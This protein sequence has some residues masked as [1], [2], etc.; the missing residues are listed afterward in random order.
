MIEVVVELKLGLWP[1]ELTISIKRRLF[2][3]TIFR[4]KQ[5]DCEIFPFRSWV[6]PGLFVFQA[7]TM[8]TSKGVFRICCAFEDLSVVCCLAFAAICHGRNRLTRSDQE[9][10][11]GREPPVANLLLRDPGHRMP[12]VHKANQIYNRRDLH[13]DGCTDDW[14]AFIRP[15][16]TKLLFILTN[17]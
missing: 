13:L 1:S 15:T 6:C 9:R 7:A 10:P 17:S 3:S 2:P 12:R 8:P 16:K 4:G 11:R 14:Q 5:L